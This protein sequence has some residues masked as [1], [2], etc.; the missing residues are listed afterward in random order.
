VTRKSSA[1]IASSTAL[2]GDSRIP[3]TG[4]QAAVDGFGQRVGVT[5]QHKPAAHNRPAACRRL[6]TGVLDAGSRE[7]RW[8]LRP[9]PRLCA[10]VQPGAALDD[11]HRS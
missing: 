4:Q 7:A 9:S 5:R 2:G 1:R 11:S 3:S 10:C 6:T 8:D